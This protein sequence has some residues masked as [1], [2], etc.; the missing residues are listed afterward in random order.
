MGAHHGAEI[1]Y[2]FGGGV[3][4][5]AFAAEGADDRVDRNLSDIMMSYWANFATTGDPNGDGLSEWS[6]YSSDQEAYMHFGDTTEQDHCL[7]RD[8]LDVLEEALVHHSGQSNIY[9]E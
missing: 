2:V 9:G 6:P 5:G 4:C 8:R 1:P 3:R 7:F